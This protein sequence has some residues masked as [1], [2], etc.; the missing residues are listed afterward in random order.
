MKTLEIK[1]KEFWSP[2]DYICDLLPGVEIAAILIS[3]VPLK[4]L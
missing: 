4:T 2:S 3:N 1:A